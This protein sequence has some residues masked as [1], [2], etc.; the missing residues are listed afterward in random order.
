MVKKIDHIAIIVKDADAALK[1]YSEMFDFKV[2]EQMA[3]PGGEFKAVLVRAGEITL[4]FLQPLKA[5][6]AFDRFLKERGGG[7][8]HVSFATDDIVK[9]LKAL[10]AQ[11]KRL[12]NEEPIVLPKA[13]IDFIHPATAENVLIELVQRG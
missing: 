7:L 1:A 6:T 11:G 13:K 10:K 3:G 8:H 4:E 2:V 12:Q 9:E 5:G